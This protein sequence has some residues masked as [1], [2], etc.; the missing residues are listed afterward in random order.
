MEDTM[1]TAEELIEFY[2]ITKDSSSVKRVRELAA[3]RDEAVAKNDTSE[4]ANIDSELN[5]IGKGG[6]NVS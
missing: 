3:K 4:I 6:H 1:A 2:E 5:N